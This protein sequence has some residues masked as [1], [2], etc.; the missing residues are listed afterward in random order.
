MGLKKMTLI[1]DQCYLLNLTNVLSGP[2]SFLFINLNLRSLEILNTDNYQVKPE[3]KSYHQ[4][5]LPLGLSEKYRLVPYQK[6]KKT[7]LSP[8]DLET[9][10]TSSGETLTSQ[11][12]SN[13]ALLREL[14]QLVEQHSRCNWREGGY[15]PDAGSDSEDATFTET[16]S[17]GESSIS[18]IDYPRE[19]GDTPPFNPP[20]SLDEGEFTSPFSPRDFSTQMGVDSLK[21]Q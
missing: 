12:S 3:N 17:D 19:G 18:L 11:G 2:L 5:L 10:E 16:T 7:P 4:H 14:V 21:F 13:R 1:G 9:Q 6:K 15:C 8:K 20:S